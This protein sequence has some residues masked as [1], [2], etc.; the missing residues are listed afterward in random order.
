VPMHAQIDARPIELEIA[1]LDVLQKCRQARI[2]QA[3]LARRRIELQSRRVEQP[4]E[5]TLNRLLE[6]ITR[7]AER[8]QCIVVRPGVAPSNALSKDR[9]R[10]CS[11]AL[12]DMSSPEA[13]SNRMLSRS[14]IARPPWLRTARRW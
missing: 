12:Q 3:D 14:S 1:Q 5:Q 6:S 4:F 10:P 8:N 7:Q 13:L 2:D 11:P 9:A